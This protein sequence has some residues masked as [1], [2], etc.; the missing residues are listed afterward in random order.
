MAADKH[1]GSNRKVTKGVLEGKI[2][3]INT[4]FPVDH[5]TNLADC[6]CGQGE[7]LICW[8]TTPCIVW[9]CMAINKHFVSAHMKS[10]IKL[11]VSNFMHK[12]KSDFLS[13]FLT[14]SH[15]TGCTH[16]ALG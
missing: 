15:P 4:F 3:N 11:Q 8:H 12:V 10:D 14:I 13:T 7:P 1:S 5:P 2:D 16:I 9:E 6:Q